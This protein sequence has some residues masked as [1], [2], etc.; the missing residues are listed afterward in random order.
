MEDEKEFL[1][2]REQ[3][4]SEDI[5]D[6]Y[7]SVQELYNDNQ[8]DSDNL[9]GCQK[10]TSTCLPSWSFSPIPNTG[11]H[12]C[13]PRS[14]SHSEYSY[15]Y[16]D[17]SNHSNTNYE[18]TH[19]MY[20]WYYTTN[21]MQN[22]SGMETPTETV[23]T[24]PGVTHAYNLP[25]FNA[26][27]SRCST[28]DLISVLATLPG[29]KQDHRTSTAKVDKL[30]SSSHYYY[31]QSSSIS[32][33]QN[34]SLMYLQ[35]TG[36]Y[37][38]SGYNSDLNLSPVYPYQHKSTNKSQYYQKCSQS[39]CTNESSEDENKENEPPTNE[40]ITY[41]QFDRDN[42]TSEMA[43][44]SVLNLAHYSSDELTAIERQIQS[45]DI[46]SSD[47][48]AQTTTNLQEN[49]LRIPCKVPS[50]LGKRKL[51]DIV[52]EKTLIATNKRQRHNQPLNNDAVKVMMNWYETHQES[53]YPN[54]AEKEQM[55][56]EG[57]ISVTQVKSWF[58]NKRNRNN[59]TRPKVQKRQ[60][61]ERL[62]DIC[63]QLA[64]DAKQPSM[65]NADIIQQL[66]SII[67]IPE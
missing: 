33:S 38:D 49:R 39:V 34:S 11:V 57:G 61:E 21:Y 5:D 26:D 24:E 60:M 9:T 54:K 19:P 44:N 27:L 14:T 28:P 51:S 62:M 32:A 18:W 30:P 17:V 35:M 43:A 59:N 42:I 4:K 16:T 7:L 8:E 37:Q 3:N 10:H 46:S 25:N 67:T 22:K 1:Q 6:L 58:A 48:R 63:H 64:R 56:K 40:I 66:S 53:P 36:G 23:K 20:N 31:A 47:F 65:N 12:L 29:E 55:A 2:S 52:V 15:S 41:E 13:Q 50:V 45:S